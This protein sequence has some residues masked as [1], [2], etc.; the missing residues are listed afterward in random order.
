MTDRNPVVRTA[1]GAVR[2]SQS[3][4]HRVFLGVPYAAPPVGAARFAA[5]R[6]HDPW[7]GVLDATE[8]GPTAPQAP[9]RLG[10][11]EMTAY[12]GSGW[13]RGP[14]YLT[15]NVWT[16][17]TTRP[18][19]PVMVFVHGGGFVAGSNRSSLYDGSRFA[20]DGVVLVT[21]N[22]RLGLPGFLDLPGAPRNRGLLDVLQALRW[23]R[24][25]IAAFGGDPGNVTLF[26]QSA[27]ATIT[28]AVLADPASEGLLRRAVV[29]SG[30]G[31]G[32]F[33]P[34]QAARVTAGAAVKLGV[35]PHAEAFAGITDDRLVEVVPGLSGIDL[36][37]ATA[38]DPLMG[39]SPFSV[40]LDR[41]PA[42]AVAG[43]Q[44]A[45]VDLLI[46]TNADE[47]N[48]YLAPFGTLS[49]STTA[50]VEATAALF[51]PDPAR[52]V[53][54]LRRSRPG[55]TAGELRSAL[56]AEALFVAGSRDLADAHAAH[57][58]SRTFRYEFAWRSPAL[59]GQLGA[60]H[61]VELPFV[62][63]VTD[64]PGLL[65]AD[66]LLGTGT[67]PAGLAARTHAAWI[68]F[69]KTGEPG[70]A[71]YERG[72]GPLMRIAEEWETVPGQRPEPGPSAG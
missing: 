71:A 34:E 46:G 35:A 14:D 8:W 49:T 63:D 56:L 38:G 12:F 2:G 69:A 16:P 68:A 23:V 37:T 25:N 52:Y 20:R 42:D 28:G 60:A 45:N 64:Q 11:L 3:E 17:R 32:A 50:D 1:Q 21:V 6:P 43:G 36:R 40:V 66:A 27:G 58:G 5:P 29:Q 26:G 70:W 13:V 19:A 55:A 62:F 7:E 4:D 31:R 41:Q 54:S 65:G 59:G 10:A 61:T 57:P 51:R 44:G 22:Y 33:T 24:E 30:N 48:L 18:G 72:D 47:G 39:L 15:V 53:A 9:R 67:P